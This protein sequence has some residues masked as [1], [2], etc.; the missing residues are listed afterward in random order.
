MSLYQ[1]WTLAQ[2]RGI[3]QRELMDPNAQWWPTAY[4]NFE[5]ANWQYELQMKYELAWGTSTVLTTNSTASYDIIPLGS[6]TPLMERLEAVYWGTGTSSGFRLAGRLLEDLERENPMWRSALPDTPREIIQ[7]DSQNAIVWPCFNGTSTYVFEYPLRMGLV[8]DTDKIGLP[9]WA[10][11]SL[12]PYVC[13]KAFL[14]PGPT[15]DLQKALRYM[16]V[17]QKEEADLKLVWDNWLP[18]RF[19]KLEPSDHYDWNIIHPPPAW[20]T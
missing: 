6:I 16:K 7:Y 10:Q 17:F 11:W 9:I 19:R 1:Q 12:K 2:A 20:S 4:L 13:W 18:E 15:N 5:I 8:N 14:R 3:V